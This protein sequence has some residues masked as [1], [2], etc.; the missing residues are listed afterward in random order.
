MDAFDAQVNVLLE[1]TAQDIKGAEALTQDFWVAVRDRKKARSLPG[2]K[3]TYCPS[4]L[5]V[6]RYKQNRGRLEAA[7]GFLLVQASQSDVAKGALGMAREIIR[8]KKWLEQA[9]RE[10]DYV[11]V[12]H[13]TDIPQKENNVERY[14]TQIDEYSH[15]L[16]NYIHTI[17]INIE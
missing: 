12:W 4:S 13:E 14:K 7:G 11:Q 16:K 3:L 9:Q 15:D 2:S 1:K 8:H 17:A 10:L 6:R 5:N